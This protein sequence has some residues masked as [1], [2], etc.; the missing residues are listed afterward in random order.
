MQVP[1]YVVCCSLAR[2][3]SSMRDMTTILR[4]DVRNWL[5][6][7]QQAWEALTLTDIVLWNVVTGWG[8]NRARRP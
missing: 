4:K 8:G 1:Q 3:F 6:L 7:L 2:I 5:E